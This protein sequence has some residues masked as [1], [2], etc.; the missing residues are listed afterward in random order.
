MAIKIEEYLTAE[1]LI[2]KTQEELFV[3]IK[4]YFE[5]NRSLTVE[6]S[7]ETIRGYKSGKV[8]SFETNVQFEDLSVEIH[9]YYAGLYWKYHVSCKDLKI[10]SL[11]PLLTL[12]SSSS[13]LLY[14]FFIIPPSLILIGGSS[15]I[16]DSKS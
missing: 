6:V 2:R 13:S 10:K 14:P 1:E 11:D 8:I 7:K 15:S 9:F 4:N 5:N 12:L 16:D 3:L